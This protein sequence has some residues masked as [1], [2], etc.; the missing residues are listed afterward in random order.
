MATQTGLQLYRGGISPRAASAH[1]EEDDADR[2]ESR[3]R[4]YM[5]EKR[6]EVDIPPD[7]DL[8]NRWEELD[9]DESAM[10]L[11]RVC[12]ERVRYVESSGDSESYHADCYEDDEEVKNEDDGSLDQVADRMAIDD[13][14]ADEQC[15]TWADEQCD[16]IADEIADLMIEDEMAAEM[17][18]KDHPDVELSDSSQVA[19]E[20]LGYKE[21]VGELCGGKATAGDM[22]KEHGQAGDTVTPVDATGGPHK[23]S[24]DY[25]PTRPSDFKA[26][27]DLGRC[28]AEQEDGNR[29]HLSETLATEESTEITSFC[30]DWIHAGSETSTESEKGPCSGVSNGSS[31][32]L[33]ARTGGRVGRRRLTQSSFVQTLR[34]YC[35]RHAS[36][37]CTT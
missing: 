22:D 23:D 30:N 27:L 4:A 20:T 1:D 5:H 37:E 21:V 36:I 33:P 9:E 11:S 2:D 12:R 15:D 7:V 32:N 13:R 8:I 26:D 34:A 17:L 6:D 24:E 16:R 28:M 14:C 25:S 31:Y 3:F 19:Q 18:V 29:A 35:G 10:D